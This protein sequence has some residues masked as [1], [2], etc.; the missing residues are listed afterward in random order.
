MYLFLIE[1][2]I[3]S[4]SGVMAPGALSAVT[5]AHGS[6]KSNAGL[7]VALGHGFVEIP[8]ILLVYFGAS[9]VIQSDLFQGFT[10]CLGGIFMLWLAAKLLRESR[11]DSQLD[12]VN[13]SSIRAGIILSLGN[14]YFLVWWA[15]VGTSL[16]FKAAEFGLLG[17]IL[18]A[19]CHW[20]CDL[21]WLWILSFLA[22][23]S[24]DLLGGRFESIITIVSVIF[25]LI[26]GCRF[27]YDFIT[28]F[29]L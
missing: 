12:E 25:L 8:L 16:V 4:L 3:I 15:T 17:L 7:R 18:F 29:N 24:G 9:N 10:R 26:M 21:V 11:G 2:V 13:Q 20:L 22:Y 28:S 6:S 23:T 5:V 14:P 27:I 19:I 1:T